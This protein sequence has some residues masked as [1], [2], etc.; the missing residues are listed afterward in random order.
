MQG[1]SISFVRN[2]EI[3]YLE[4]IEKK[5]K[6][7][8]EIMHA[9]SNTNVKKAKKEHVVEMIK[10]VIEDGRGMKHY[11]VAS[12]LIELFGAEMALNAALEIISPKNL[13]VLDVLSKEPPV[14]VKIRKRND[15]HRGKKVTFNKREELSRFN[16][17]RH[18]KSV[19]SEKKNSY[20]KKGKTF[21]K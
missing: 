19:R 14:V 3:D 9:P 4:L 16:K 10:E 8:I 13:P 6:S 12:K 2:I 18:S 17:D 7:E 1:T 21:S 5:T 20:A 15:F 11:D